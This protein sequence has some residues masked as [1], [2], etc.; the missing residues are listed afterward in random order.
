MIDMKI[1]I[2]NSCIEADLA[3]SFWKHTIGLSF[4]KK[5]NMLFVMPF[6]DRWPFWMFGVRYPLTM[7]FIDKEKKVVDV[8][9]AKPL[10]LDIR[11]L[12]TYAPSKKCK[13]ILESP[14]SLKLK[15]GER[16]SW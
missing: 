4:S 15:I 10:S 3:D 9:Q 2:R 5:K 1:K 12:R 13:Y 8:K 11:T 14:F 7:V 16:L 6:N